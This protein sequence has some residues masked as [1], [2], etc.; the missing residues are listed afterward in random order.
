VK[1]P[2]H[3]SR[4][5]RHV[6][7]DF[8]K[9]SGED[10]SVRKDAGEGQKGKRAGLVWILAFFLLL[11]PLSET[12]ANT[13]I[14]AWSG[15]QQTLGESSDSGRL[16]T[17]LQHL[18]KERRDLGLR[19]IPSFSR[20]LSYAAD[21]QEDPAIRNLLLR[22]AK[23]LDPLLPTPR[24]LA[25]EM[26]WERGRFVEALGE[27]STGVLNLF[28]DPSS[29]RLVLASLL[30]W[31]SLALALSVTLTM[32]I[33]TL[34]YFR[35][36]VMDSVHLSE[37]IFS[38]ANAVVLA[39]VIVGLPLCAGM[40]PLWELIYLFALTWSYTTFRHRMTGAV[41]VLV[42]ALLMPLLITWQRHGLTEEPLLGRVSEML[43]K[44]VGDFNSLRAF[45]EL[46]RDIEPSAAYHIVSGELFRIHGDLD[47][48]Q[49]EFEKAA[50]LEPGTSLPRL[51]LG[52][53][54][55]ENHDIGRAL[56]YLNDTI[57]RDP[58]SVLG[59]YNLAVALDLTRR[60]EEGDQARNRARE[61]SGGHYEKIGWPGREEN[62]LYPKIGRDM[63][64]KVVGDTHGLV[65]NSLVGGSGIPVDTDTFMQ[66]LSA[67]A[68][69]GLIFGGIILSLRKSYF[70]T[71]RE[72]T[73]CG[74]VFYAE[75]K[76]VY[77]EQCV[78]VFLRRNAVS[79]DQQAAKVAQV[80][81]WELFSS[82][83]RRMAGVFCPGGSLV[84][85]GSLIAGLM[86]S[87]VVWTLLLGALIWIPFFMRE[88]N[89]FVPWL[90]FQ[91]ILA[92]LGIGIWVSLA[93][94]AWYR[95]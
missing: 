51:F 43:E 8:C 90:V 12:E 20:A 48:A 26:E 70:P 17:A 63:L 28:R 31:W 88:V 72:C 37:K 64:S 11:L 25:A 23:E 55:L 22:T 59:Y 10:G 75:D 83:S 61:I 91:G 14:D 66:P 67:A 89:T 46:S 58:N 49:M 40:G 81:R 13:L 74:K 54:A 38:R 24:F 87:L 47:L 84:A 56:E 45:S 78:T 95:R 60:F 1:G 52:V 77:C 15:V 21:S 4:N 18:L 32:L 41:M 82:M 92:L 65:R 73:K 7:V 6:F 76:T 80:R 44:R 42:L 5:A 36:I 33:L 79:I 85:S 69:F 34:R 50:V 71:G 2:Q 9:E 62:I 29:R 93:V 94:S 27:F 86:M 19:R 57:S 16:T 35:L 39:I 68:I 30:P 3:F 53:M